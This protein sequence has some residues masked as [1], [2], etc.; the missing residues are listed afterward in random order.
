MLNSNWGVRKWSAYQT[1]TDV[2]AIT[3][4]SYA[5]TDASGKPTFYMTAVDGKC[6]MP[7]SSYSKN[8][9]SP[10]EC[11]QVLVGIKYLFN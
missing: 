11:W 2:T 8:Y 1:S 5:G 3:P 7:E 4:L 9:V 6:A 10:T